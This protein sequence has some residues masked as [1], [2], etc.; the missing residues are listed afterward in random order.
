MEYTFKP[1]LFAKERTLRLSDSTLDII[2]HEGRT[3]HSM[4]LR[5]V[6]RVREFAGGFVVDPEKGKVP[7]TQCDVKFE[8]GQSVTIKSASYVDTEAGIDQTPQ[9]RAFLTRLN[10]TI[11]DARPDTPLIV[12]SMGIAMIWIV[13]GLISVAFL[14]FGIALAVS[15]LFT[16]DSFGEVMVIGAPI[17]ITWLLMTKASQ[18]MIRVYWPQRLTV[19]DYAGCSASTW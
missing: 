15:P 17:L 11:A 18:R 16:N 4:D 2:D 7:M 10:E 8:S 3:G 12:G 13:L 5:W 1:N 9:Y 14:L 19:A 6:R